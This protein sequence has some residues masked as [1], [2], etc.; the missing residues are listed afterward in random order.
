[1][2]QPPDLESLSKEEET[3]LAF[4][5]IKKPQEL[6][7]RRAAIVYKVPR[8]TL[9]QRRARTQSTRNTH[10]KSSNLTKAEEQTLVQYI[11]KL[12][13]RG[14]TPTLRWVEHMAN[15]L[16]AARDAKPVGPRWA[17]NFVK[18]VPGL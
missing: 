12:D 18:R 17:S 1:M 14:L 16:R 7:V 13:E 9:Q 5:A 8:T 6:S 15:H 2:D 10:P 4:Q 3:K 11:R